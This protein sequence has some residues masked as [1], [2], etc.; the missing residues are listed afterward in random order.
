[1]K[2]NRPFWFKYRFVLI[3]VLVMGAVL[4][5]FFL[6]K[7]F[8][9]GEVKCSSQ[10][11]QCNKK[12]EDFLI[13][14]KDKS[15]FA[16][17][18]SVK[19]YL[20]TDS[21]IK[22]FSVKYEYPDKIILDIVERKPILSVKTQGG[23]YLLISSD[24]KVLGKASSSSLP[25]L[26]IADNEIDLT[27]ESSSDSAFAFDLLR[28][29]DQVFGVKFGSVMTDSIQFKIQDGPL[30]IYPKNGDVILMVGALRLISQNLLSNQKEYSLEKPYNQITID[31]RYNNP[32]IN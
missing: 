22:M 8:L 26:E 7:R 1:V 30:V 6:N 28:Y 21:L 32:V 23:T 31:L 27:Q 25:Y 9:V 29:M 14:Q 5:L 16:A 18:K 17:R 3:L 2:K 4:L 11:G 12:I 10:Y 15:Y 19:N 13:G 20:S 24:Y